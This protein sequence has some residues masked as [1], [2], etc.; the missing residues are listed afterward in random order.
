M[1][2]QSVK[3]RELSV[4]MREQS[5][6]MREQSVKMK[7]QSVKMKEQ[8]VKMREQT[9]K[10]EGTVCEDEGTD[11]KDEGTG[12]RS[13]VLKK[14]LRLFLLQRFSKELCQSSLIKVYY[15]RKDNSINQSVWAEGYTGHRLRGSRRRTAAQRCVKNLPPRRL[16]PRGDAPRVLRNKPR[17]F[18][19]RWNPDA[20][21]L[22]MLVSLNKPKLRL[23]RG[24][25]RRPQLQRHGRSCGGGGNCSRKKKL[26]RLRDIFY[27]DT[28]TETRCI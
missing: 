14:S 15:K 4:K 28:A 3:M 23:K 19:F 6:K 24:E 5:V 25:Q 2:E 8:S 18:R 22:L 1:R 17:H 27:P 20:S 21:P 16:D 13:P 11:C 9:V 26:Q 12:A 10:D 7:E